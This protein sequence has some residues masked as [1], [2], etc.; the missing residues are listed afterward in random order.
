MKSRE[1]IPLKGQSHKILFYCHGVG[2]ITND[3]FLKDCYFNGF[4]FWQKE[5]FPTPRYVT[6]ARVATPCYAALHGVIKK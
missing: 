4:C 1:T 3:Q 6:Q 2:K 5:F